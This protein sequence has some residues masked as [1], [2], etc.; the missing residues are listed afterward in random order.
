LLTKDEIAWINSYHA[1]VRELIGPEMGP[2]Y[3]T[4]LETATAP[5]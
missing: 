4:W 2:D 5:I 3:K 1:R